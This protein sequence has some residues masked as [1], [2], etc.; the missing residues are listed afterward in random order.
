[1]AL[2]CFADDYFVAG[3]LYAPQQRQ[4]V[5][6][7]R[8]LPHHPLQ[9]LP[10]S[11]HPAAGVGQQPHRLHRYCF[12]ARS[13]SPVRLAG[14][15]GLHLN[16]SF[17]V[18]RLHL[19]HC[20]YFYLM[21]SIIIIAIFDFEAPA[22]SLPFARSIA[23]RIVKITDVQP[24]P[25]A[26]QSRGSNPVKPVVATVFIAAGLLQHCDQLLREQQEVV[27]VDSAAAAES[28]LVIK[29]PCFK[30]DQSSAHGLP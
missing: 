27:G 29:R 13:G 8:R 17:C 19:H 18:P 22:D 10:L 25:V 7:L 1:M 28:Y 26:K 21:R 3:P 20:V 2:G 14:L 24:E 6:H 23:T 16:L 12:S 4:L 9:L 15:V 11:L 5:D 30:F